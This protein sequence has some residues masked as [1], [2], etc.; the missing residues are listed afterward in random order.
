MRIDAEFDDFYEKCLK[1]LKARDNWTEAFI[2]L[3]ERYC[4]L[5]AKLNK[6]NV[7]IVDEEVIV[8]HTNKAKETNV[9][10]SPTWRMFLALNV[11]A[12]RLAR[13]LKLCPESAPR[14]EKKEAT[15]PAR[16]KLE[17]SA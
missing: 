12:N 6:L 2:P 8:Q 9:A 11:E 1:E 10:S 16:F 15:G 3:L 7:S 4:T 5:T 17:K 14:K 13:Q